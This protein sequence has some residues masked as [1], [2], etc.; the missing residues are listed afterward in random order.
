MESTPPF[1]S[2][3]D[4]AAE[5]LFHF[6]I[7]REDVK[8]LVA[9]LQEDSSADRNTVEYELQIL[10]IIF[11]GWGIS[12]ALQ[13]LP[14]RQELAERYWKIVYEFSQ[15]ISATTGLMTSREIDYFQ[16]VRLRLDKY[17]AAMQQDSS[18]DP[19]GIIG[20]EFALFCDDAEDIFTALTGSKLF[21]S[22]IGRVKEYLETATLDKPPLLH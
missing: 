7:D 8:W 9:S 4:A 13:D 5:D 2:C 16:I 1:A 11:V 20:R 6:A 14:H 15:K 17:L 3:I 12:Y 18:A 19:T 21:T 22:A 10:K